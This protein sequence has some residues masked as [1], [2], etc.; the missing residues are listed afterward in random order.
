[1]S[2]NRRDF[3]KAAA[4]ASGVSL[5]AT[6]LGKRIP[7]VHADQSNPLPHPDQSNIQNIVIV[8]MEN[9]SFDHMLGWM[10]GARGKQSGLIYKDKNG[11]QH[12]THRLTSYTGCPHP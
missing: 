5:A 11:A 9:R 6:N 4:L 2:I 12:S 7:L 10:P 1:M 3:L 8:M